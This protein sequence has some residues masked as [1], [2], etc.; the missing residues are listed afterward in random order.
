M[1][2]Y[3]D[4]Q[5]KIMELLGFPNWIIQAWPIFRGENCKEIRLLLLTYGAAAVS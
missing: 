1:R 4:L 5:P 2:N 3:L